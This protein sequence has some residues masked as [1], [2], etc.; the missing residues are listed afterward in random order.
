MNDPR[1][2]PRAPVLTGVFLWLLLCAGCATPQI[3]ALSS[4]WPTDLPAQVELR[5]IAFFPQE[6]FECGPAALATIADAA[7]VHVTPEALVAQV[8]VPARKGSLQAEMLA[9]ARRQGL[10]AYPLGP[11]VHSVLREVAAG[12]PVLVLQNLAF[13][14]Y[15]V[16]H[17]A[18]VI[19]YDRERNVL[20]LRS[21][22]TERLEMSL[23]T[24]ERTWARAQYW[25]M[26]ALPPSRLPASAE[27]GTYTA[28]VA[29]LERIDP[30]AARRAYASAL[31]AW[32]DDRAAMLGL[33]NTAYALGQLGAAVKAYRRAVLRHADFAEAWNN[34]AQVLLETG[35]R[36]Q[37]AQAV[38]RAV[39]LG[40]EHLQRYRQLQ[41]EIGGK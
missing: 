16:W 24:F 33:G 18:V 40:G 26:L 7:G 13:S 15:P 31:R 23:F 35:R 12:H 30:R 17:Y 34:L 19:G 9:A 36:S 29:A 21:G 38:A 25:S 1:P 37:A 22:R 4:Q 14:F 27:S 10:V 8:Y 6:D 5:K 28:A 41:L 32:P 11:S 3:A 20:L 39:A 2:A